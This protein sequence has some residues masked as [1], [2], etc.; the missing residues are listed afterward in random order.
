[1]KEFI[2]KTCGKTFL[3]KKAD[4]NETPKYCSKECCSESQKKYKVCKYCGKVF[5]N[6]ANEKYCSAEC[7]V[8]ST[9][10]MVLSAEKRKKLSNGR[11]QSD[12]CKGVNLYNW[13]GGKATLNDR[14]KLAYHK[15]RSN[16]RIRID[17]NYLIRLY[18]AQHGKCFYC[19]TD[20]SKYKAIE[21]LTP[22]SKGGDNDNIN[23]VFSCRSCNSKKRDLSLEEY[24]I[25]TRKFK[26]LDKYDLIMILAL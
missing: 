23:I 10:G 16:Q 18:K 12:K 25:K 14:M 1:M 3:S 21:H 6:W 17:K 4:K 22:V 5:A 7:R 2:C 20:L 26:L 15:R 8:S 19:G 9:R 24:A 11:K 13:K